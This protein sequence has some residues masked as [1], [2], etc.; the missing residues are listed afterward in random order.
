M[1]VVD[2]AVEALLKHG[3]VKRGFLGVRTQLVPLPDSLRSLPDVEQ[4]NALLIVGLENGGP[5]EKSG[6]QLGDTLIAIGDKTVTD[7]DSLRSVLRGLAA[8]E[9]VVLKV[10][11][12]GTL[13][14][15]DVTLGTSA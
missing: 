4:E 9:V 15:V 13:Q 6:V 14:T 2:A 10:I 5:A 1:P 3:G 12:G 11:R 8:G 7:V